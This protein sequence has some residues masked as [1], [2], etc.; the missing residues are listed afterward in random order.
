MNRC[1]HVWKKPEEGD[2]FKFCK[3]C[4]KRKKIFS[5]PRARKSLYDKAY[6]LWKQFAH[7]RDG[8]GCMIKKV[9]PELNLIHTDVMN[10]DHFCPRG[11]HNLHLETCN[12]TIICSAC[13]FNKSNG[14]LNETL[15]NC[16]VRDIV[17]RREGPE[18]FEWMMELHNRRPLNRRWM[19]EDWLEEQIERLKGEIKD[20]RT[21]RGDSLIGGR[22]EV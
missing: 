20:L 5:K 8:E 6:S 4:H 3:K 2:I 13:N 14:S 22:G 10:V 21:V 7:L 16:A 19:R 9:F 12:A 18:K 15:I 1:K 11:D 17:H